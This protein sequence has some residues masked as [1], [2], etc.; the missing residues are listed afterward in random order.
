M[1][2][3]VVAKGL[4]DPSGIAIAPSGRV[5]VADSE[6]GEV[7]V[8]VSNGPAHTFISG[9]R[10]P[11]GIAVDTDE[12]VLVSDSMADRIYR[13]RADGELIS[14]FGKT[15]DGDGEFSGTGP[16][17]IGEDGSIYVVD[18]DHNRIQVFDRAGVFRFT[19]GKEGHFGNSAEGEL[20]FPGG[21]ATDSR[22]N[23]YV[24]DTH[25]FR[26]QV[27][28][29]KG[30][31]QR[32]WGQQGT[33]RGEFDHPF[34]I[35]EDGER[36]RVYVV[37]DY[38]KLDGGGNRIQVF[39]HSGRYL[40]SSTVALDHPFDVAV[41]SDGRVFVTERGT[42]S[43]RVLSPSDFEIATNTKATSR[44]TSRPSSHPRSRL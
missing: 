1:S 38:I 14:T 26:V 40:G 16:L 31:F 37:D 17:A 3:G 25:N 2:E 44:P 18:I 33:W 7:L 42:G 10:S 5:Y 23:V 43:V 4:L 24:S 6:R 15:G 13:Y 11:L 35:A 36:D 32:S 27:F 41:A 12:S 39:S 19:F 34:G 8:L 9:L 28:S 29:S 30:E 22:G 21:I 20:Y